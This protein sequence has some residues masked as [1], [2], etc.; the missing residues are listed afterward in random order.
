MVAPN[1]E[2]AVAEALTASGL[3]CDA[4]DV[5]WVDG[6]RGLRGAV[7]A[8][9]LAVARAHAA[10]EPADL[11]LVE[12]RLSPEGV[13]LGL[14]DTYDLTDTSGVDESRPLVR[15]HARQASPPTSI[16]WRRASLPRASCSASATP[17]I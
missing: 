7:D 2:T 16:S 5:A 10:G 11:Y 12:A 14:G 8:S 13:V 1:S 9:G 3:A 4:S 15:G 6:P 17:T